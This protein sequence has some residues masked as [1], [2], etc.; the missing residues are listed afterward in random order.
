MTNVL[1]QTRIPPEADYAPPPPGYTLFQLE[2][3]T[4]FRLG[5]Q[6]LEVGFTV[7]N[8]LNTSYREYL[9]R[10]RYFTDEP[11]RNVSLRLRLPFGLKI[12]R[13]EGV[14]E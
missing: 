5:R 13:G 1:E 4:Q 12:G 6:P 2:G 14:L 7:F 9:N 10:F 8:L 11:G 3:R